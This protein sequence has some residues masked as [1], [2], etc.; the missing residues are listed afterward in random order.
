MIIP[1]INIPDNR[2]ISKQKDIDQMMY[3]KM[4]DIQKSN[5]TKEVKKVELQK[6]T[7]LVSS[8]WSHQPLL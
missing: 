7:A 6:Y 8:N 4:F 2:M 3:G 5:K 1:T